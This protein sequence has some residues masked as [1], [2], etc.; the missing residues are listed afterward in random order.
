MQYCNAMNW[1]DI[2]YFLSLRD[3]GSLSR[4][5][6]QLGVNQSTVFRRIRELEKDLGATLFDRRHSG[7][8]RLT[9]HG[10]LL[11]DQARTMESASTN[12]T[13][14]IQGKDEELSG[15]IRVTAPEDVAVLS[16]SHHLVEFRKLYPGISIEL[17]TSSRYFSLHRGEADIAIRASGAPTEDNVIPRKMADVSASLFASPAYLEKTGNPQHEEELSRHQLIGWGGEL[18]GG[19]PPFFVS[20][21]KP[22]SSNS[23]LVQKT[24]AEQ[25]MGIALLPEFLGLS[26]P[27]LVPV[28]PELKQSVATLW[29]LYHAELRH[30][31]RIQAFVSYIQDAL[32]KDLSPAGYRE[33]SSPPNKV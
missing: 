19:N 30:T 20:E 28:L 27:H 16:L 1:N 4:A 13:R 9:Q 24:L 10:E 14:Q 29:L 3:Q 26:S 18:D 17:L 22:V 8:Y 33:A 2:R 12:I 23:L 11:L 15:L 7:E 5:A 21:N 25:G 6:E 32:R 31:A